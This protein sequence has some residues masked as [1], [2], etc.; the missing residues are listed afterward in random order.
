MKTGNLVSKLMLAASM[1]FIFTISVQA[2]TKTVLSTYLD[3]KDALVKTNA[4]DASLAANGMVAILNDKS[5]E[6]SKKLLTDAKAI[7]ANSDVKV[8]RKYFDKLSQN[9]YDY[10]KE[11]GEKD[12]TIYKQFCPMAFNNSGA[13]WLAA[14]KEINNP[15]FG[16]MMLHC[17]SVKEEL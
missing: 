7:S 11:T 16:S 1:S 15:Y 4:K 2:Q 6:L 9:V 10:V 17:G 3:I 13:Y 8:Q 12:G 14:E 5:D